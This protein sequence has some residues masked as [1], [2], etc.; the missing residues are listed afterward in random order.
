MGSVQQL[1]IYME[2]EDRENVTNF[3]INFQTV[4]DLSTK[5]NK[6]HHLPFRVSLVQL[7]LCLSCAR[8]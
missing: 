3:L 5:I 7:V 1:C 2:R 4:L 6:T 8:T